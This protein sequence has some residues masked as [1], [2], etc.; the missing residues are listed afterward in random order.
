MKKTKLNSR[1]NFIKKSALLGIGA[2]IPIKSF[3]IG[4]NLKQNNEIIG[5]GDFKYKVDKKWG[6]QNANDFPV[7]HCHEMVMDNK[8]RIFMTTTHP[9]NNVLIY[10]QSGK[11]EGSWSIGYSSAHGLTIVDE[12]G[13]EFLYITDPDKHMVCKTDLKGRKILELDYP[14]EIKEYNSAEDFKPTETTVA[15]NGDIFI[16]DGYGK[17]FIIK[18]DSKGNYIKHFGGR[19]DKSNQF[20]CCHGITLDTREKNNPSLLISSRTKNE[21]K[22]FDL[23]GKHIE[24]IPLP[25][26]WICRPVIKGNNLF[27]AVIITESWWNYD[28]ML[29]IL[30]HNNKIISLPGGDV[31]KYI[32][33]VLQ[34]PI[35]DQKTFLNPHDVCI[36]NDD[37]I[38]IPQWNSGKTYPVKLIR[39]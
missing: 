3:S 5:H 12:G 13:E 14:K 16:A 15:P 27:F 19:G 4:K 39:T 37:S 2:S 25:G 30:D 24:T 20:D 26:C 29:A 31:P 38:Y 35:Y 10:N 34:K 11:I 6:V 8:N 32:D 23:N 33:G 28:G 17:D 1:R 7:N 36:D 18:Y 21:F 22:R 9:K